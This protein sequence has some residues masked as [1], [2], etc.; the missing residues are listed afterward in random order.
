VAI[1]PPPSTIA[2]TYEEETRL[3]GFPT[4][5][6]NG[7]LPETFN[8]GGGIPMTLPTDGSWVC[9]GTVASRLIGPAG[10]LASGT[11]INV[12]IYDPAD[13]RFWYSGGATNDG[14]GFP[15]ELVSGKAGNLHYFDVP[16]ILKPGHRLVLYASHGG[17]AAPT[18]NSPL[19]VGLICS[20]LPKG[21][22][23]KMLTLES[24][25]EA[26]KN[27]D[28]EMYK[29][30]ANF[31]FFTANLADQASRKVQVP[32][33]KEQALLV[34][35]ITAR[36]DLNSD[37]DPRVTEPNILLQVSDS[38]NLSTWTQP[39]PA[40]L[41]AFSGNRGARIWTPATFF[42]VMPGMDLILE[43]TNRTGAALVADLP[44]VLHCAN[45]KGSF[46]R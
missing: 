33:N 37:L 10:S 36:F 39:D 45:I 35:G 31:N 22:D 8:G 23:A 21:V 6:F 28:G 11:N 44:F 13:S 16:K 19:Y 38:R 40:P 2:N 1:V 34:T 15:L 5:D 46:T 18:A 29:V 32:L 17:A 43:V 26:V 3:F 7:V 14:V 41:S 25:S 12:N 42:L 30:R 9:W 4:F 24:F 20:L 27:R